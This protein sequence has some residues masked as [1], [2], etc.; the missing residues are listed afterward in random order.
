[1]AHRRLPADAQRTACGACGDDVILAR[2][3]L[4]DDG[5]G[6]LSGIEPGAPRLLDLYEII[7]LQTCWVCRGHGRRKAR[8]GRS[9]ACGR[10]GGTGRAGEEVASTEHLEALDTRGFVRTTTLKKRRTGEALHRIHV[11]V[12][13]PLE[14]PD[15]DDD[16]VSLMS[17]QPA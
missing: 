12:R 13:S 10:C 1:V 15:V 11:C 6:H 3:N 9:I 16:L 17:G 7:P 8:N 14:G 2:P 5:R 4:L